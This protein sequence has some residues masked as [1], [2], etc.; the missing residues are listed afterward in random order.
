MEKPIDFCS[1]FQV[2]NLDPMATAGEVTEQLVQMN[3]LSDPKYYGIFQVLY[4]GE[5]L[6]FVYNVLGL[7]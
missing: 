6:L 2:L 5:C 4:A 1:V 3:G 7:L